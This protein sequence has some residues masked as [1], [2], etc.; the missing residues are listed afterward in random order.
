V[1]RWEAG[2]PL[3][4]QLSWA[5]GPDVLFVHAGAV[6]GPEGAALIMGP[7]GAGKSSTSLACLRAGM[8]YLGDDYCLVRGDPPM[9][10]LLYST[11][12]LIDADVVHFDDFVE[13]ASLGASVEEPEFR[14][15][16]KALYLLDG[17]QR[18]SLLTRA[19]VKVVIVPEARGDIEPR[20]EPIRRAEVM[21]HVAPSSLWQ[22]SVEPDRELAALARLV[23]SVPCFKLILGRDRE[24]NPPLIRQLL[25]D[26]G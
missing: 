15:E 7:S 6:G 4:R 26:L 25:E 16:A 8:G 2:S 20:V 24:A 10:H 19:P 13:P 22:M 18:S 9:V 12:R 21:R 11:A 1:T 17:S 14:D 3:R 23:K 5:L